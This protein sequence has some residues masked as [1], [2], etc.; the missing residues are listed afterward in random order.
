MALRLHQ[1]NR[2]LKLFKAS[3]G[4]CYFRNPKYAF[5]S[6]CLAAHP[7]TSFQRHFIIKKFW[8]HTHNTIRY[9]MPPTYVA[10][11]YAP[12]SNYVYAAHIA[13]FIGTLGLIYATLAFMFR[14]ESWV[15]KYDETKIGPLKQMVESEFEIYVYLASFL[16]LLVWVFTAVRR[17][18]LRIYYN[19]SKKEF[20]A[21]SLNFL[22]STVKKVHFTHGD[23]KEVANMNR[24]RRDFLNDKYAVGNHRFVIIES[25]FR[26]L[27]Y[28][29]LMLGYVQ[30]Y[31]DEEEQ[32]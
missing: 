11:Y 31:T 7:H 17:Y 18:P 10:V 20:V 19:E 16:L 2:L 12:T 3:N 32:N 9:N 22:P 24:L 25:E 30:D 21:C 6:P 13:V 8:K 28:L 14:T 29:N 1:V 23:M 26:T 15:S 5:V 4:Y 27:Y